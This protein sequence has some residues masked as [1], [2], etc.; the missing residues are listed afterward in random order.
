LAY[1]YSS[2][3]KRLE[4]PNPYRVEN[5]FLALCAACTFAGGLLGLAWAR[6]A[7]AA[8]A[9]RLGVAPLL[10]GA[11][12][13]AASIGFAVVAARRLRFFFGR[14][15][16]RSLAPEVAV[17]ATGNSPRADQ[18][19]AMLRQGGLEYPEPQGALNGL[20]YHAV[21]RLI[22]AP[23]VVQGLAQRQFFNA[24]AFAVTLASFACAWGLLGSAQTRPLISIA[25][26]LFGAL[27]LLRPLVTGGEARLGTRELVALVV[28]AVVG[29][30]AA[31]L[32]GP[33]LP[34][35]RF[36]MAGQAFA[37][38][39]CA[40]LAVVLILAAL[41][42]QVD[43][44][45]QTERSCEQRTL[46]MNGP[47]GALVT[48]L[49]RRL[50]DA[51]TEE[52]PNRRYTRLDPAIESAAGS[53]RFAGELM[54]E[55]QPMP[56]AGSAATGLGGALQGRRH[57]WLV[58]V[59][60]YATLLVLLGTTCAL[61]YVRGFDPARVL[62]DGW[63]SPATIGYAG[64]CLAI[65]AFCFQSTDAIWG[66]F[67]F[68]SVLVWVE[69]LGTWQASRISTGNQL[70]SRLQTVNEVARVESMTLRVWRARVESVVFGKDGARQVTAMYAT[71]QE[72][73]R[74]ASELEAFA[75]RQSVFMAP[76]AQ[77]DLHRIDALQATEA[78]LGGRPPGP[79]APQDA[80]DTA[81]AAH[82]AL[83]VEQAH[84]TEGA[85]R[86]C[87]ACGAK[88]A[89]GARF[90]SACGTALPAA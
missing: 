73:A 51:W 18:L 1:D 7:I 60:L 44:A 17:G 14:G 68:E 81:A 27:V 31:G 62:A 85:P 45:P 30:V 34:S 29:P 43:A 28:V 75:A 87:S 8:H 63:G 25:Y 22:T 86:H 79:R 23:L 65:A 78:A 52:I 40:L 6:E 69:M 42:A 5:A 37:L 89:A 56:V 11:A 4:L 2:E 77:E 33:A 24:L 80:L 32:L 88:A 76:R 59:D 83:R 55:S 35:L 19:K 38:L 50:Q 58:V 67:D 72:A 53:G 13:V 54:E 84:A 26:F 36:A 10:V 39:A 70:A 21:P 82:D 12:L 15:R 71:A 57:R 3:N 9:L 16:P 74:L 47:P 41:L 20:L 90:C 66:R 46:S 61:V 49:D 48:E 64:V